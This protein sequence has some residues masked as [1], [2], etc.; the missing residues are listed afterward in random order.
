M[1]NQK[2]MPLEWSFQ[3]NPPGFGHLSLHYQV[4]CT[5]IAFPAYGRLPHE[6][7]LIT[8]TEVPGIQLADHLPGTIREDSHARSSLSAGSDPAEPNW[9]SAVQSG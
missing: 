6:L 5:I 7:Q 1:S 4:P 9:T 8:C 2:T 3:G